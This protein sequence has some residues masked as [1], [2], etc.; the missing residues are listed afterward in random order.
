MRTRIIIVYMTTLKCKCKI[1]WRSATQKYHVALAIYSKN[2]GAI[3]LNTKSPIHTGPKRNKIDFIFLISL[4][5]I[6]VSSLSA[7]I[8]ITYQDYQIF[9]G[10]SSFIILLITYHLLFYSYKSSTTI[11]TIKSIDYFWIA[12][13]LVGLIKIESINRVASEE[14]YRRN[15][16]NYPKIVKSLENEFEL[17]R[18]KYCDSAG[19]N[20]SANPPPYGKENPCTSAR[21]ILELIRD[22]KILESIEY[23]REFS[24]KWE[25][26]VFFDDSKISVISHNPKLESLITD[27]Y[28]AEKWIN[29]PASKVVLSSIYWAIDLF[30][31][32]FFIITLALRATKT[33][34]EIFRWHI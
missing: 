16:D 24:N 23:S 17:L 15:M 19:E 11:S 8:S 27:L 33:T 28:H 34:A 12:L 2:N 3:Q 31:F 22:N 9:I 1:T 20:S 5:T 18:I 29:L 4:T 7:I 25:T 6:I 13:A 10:L 26:S 21:Y 30:A 32:W 14:L